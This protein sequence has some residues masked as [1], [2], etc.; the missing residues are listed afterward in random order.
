[1]FLPNEVENYQ[2]IKASGDLKDRIRKN[3]DVTHKRNRKKAI[4]LTA[5]MACLALLIFTGNIY[6]LKNHVL[7]VDGVP[8]LYNSRTIDETSPFSVA[9]A[10]EEQDLQICV[11]LK[12]RVYQETVIT[13]SDG[14]IT[15]KEQNNAD[16]ENQVSTLHINKPEDLLWYLY[17]D[18]TECKQCIILTGDKKYVY[19]L[20][21]EE[22]TN[23]Y[24]IR[25]LENK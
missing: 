18:D 3:V 10:S 23:S 24:N 22:K 16:L 17:K 4:R 6:L 25:Q 5:A 19:E 8:V 20:V 12:V 7:S 21:F 13:V 1:M 9:N 2:Q 14:T 11:P 15:T